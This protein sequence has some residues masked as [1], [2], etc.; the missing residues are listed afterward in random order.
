MRRWLMTEQFL[1]G[2]TLYVKGIR[3]I[4]DLENKMEDKDYR[5]C[6]GDIEKLALLNRQVANLMDTAIKIEVIREL[7]EVIGDIKDV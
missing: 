6:N 1:K 3:R 7:K 2:H 4:I 5:P